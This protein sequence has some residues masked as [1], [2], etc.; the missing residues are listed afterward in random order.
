MR[1]VILAA[2]IATALYS[3]N[4]HA[5]EKIGAYLQEHG[6]S[7]TDSAQLNPTS[8]KHYTFTQVISNFD[9]G[10]NSLHYKP[11]LLAVRGTADLVVN[12]KFAFATSRRL[13]MD[14]NLASAGG[15][16]G[17]LSVC[18]QFD[19]NN[20]DL[21]TLSYDACLLQA[22]IIDGKLATEVMVAN[23]IDELIAVIWFTDKK[24]PPVYR[25][26]LL[27]TDQQTISWR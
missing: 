5:S 11:G 12:P 20:T 10:W 3:A 14:I 25:R 23:H 24:K 21:A 27:E 6:W 16:H 15:T 2:A 4:S 22:S 13:Q 17:F 8:V 19:A 18:S 1:N 7:T 26:F 9:S